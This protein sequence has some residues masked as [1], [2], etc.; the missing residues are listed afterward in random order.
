M[1]YLTLIIFVG[2]AA[3]ICLLC[4][5]KDVESEP[6][7]FK[8]SCYDIVIE[9]LVDDDGFLYYYISS[10]KTHCDLSYEDVVDL[11]AKEKSG[12][13]IVL[14]YEKSYSLSSCSVLVGDYLYF[15]GTRDH[16]D[17]SDSVVGGRHTVV[18]VIKGGR[19][20][21]EKNVSYQ[22]KM[23]IFNFR[24]GLRTER[25]GTK[26]NSEVPGKT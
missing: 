24:G 19:S 16:K 17:W 7:G 4:K 3:F 8:F 1:R 23:Y 13:E 2:V 12:K 6:N 10:D 9:R 18:A 26:C 14:L 21:F 5:D 25:Q 15:F 11:L 20:G 22:R